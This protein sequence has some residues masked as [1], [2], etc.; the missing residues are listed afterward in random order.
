[1]QMFM[2]QICNLKV[3]MNDKYLLLKK[4]NSNQLNQ[5]NRLS[6]IKFLC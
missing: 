1:M 3:Q 5:S 2:K 6:S 4:I